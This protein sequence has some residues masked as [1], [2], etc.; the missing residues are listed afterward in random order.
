MS[1]AKKI[2]SKAK[3]NKSSRVQKIINFFTPSSNKNE[4]RRSIRTQPEVE[5]GDVNTANIINIKTET[6]KH[7]L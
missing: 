6:R 4:Q 5:T 1:T 3:L 7:G 2:T